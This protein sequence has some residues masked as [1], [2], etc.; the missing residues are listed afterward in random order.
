MSTPSWGDWAEEDGLF[1][2]H[3]ACQ[4]YKPELEEGEILDPYAADVPSGL[5][6]VPPAVST[7]RTPPPLSYGR[8]SHVP[9]Q[10]KVWGARAN[11]SAAAAAAS[12]PPP[13]QKQYLAMILMRQRFWRDHTWYEYLLERRG[14][15]FHFPSTGLE[16]FSPEEVILHNCAKRGMLYK[17]DRAQD[18]EACLQHTV[19]AGGR[20]HRVYLLPWKTTQR[21]KSERRL[22]SPPAFFWLTESEMAAHVHVGPPGAFGISIGMVSLQAMSALPLNL[23]F[24]SMTPPIVLYHGTDVVTAGIIAASGMLPTAKVGMLGPGMYFARWDKARDFA[25]ET[26]ERVRRE[27]PGCVVRAIVQADSVREMTSG[28]V[29]TCGCAKTYVDHNGHHGTGADIT[30]VP[31]NSLPATRRA[32]WCIRNPDCILVDGLFDI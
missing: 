23:Q 8:G 21:P 3:G 2:A 31:D 20:C 22:K 32:E 4:P 9:S 11:P 15:E 29:C 13:M 26:A 7:R 5:K 19:M 6:R 1:G 24:A 16:G 18:L 17:P 10:H 28:D 25:T 30:F 27:P 12:R 14:D